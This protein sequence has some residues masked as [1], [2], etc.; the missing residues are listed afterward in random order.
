MTQLLIFK[1]VFD[2]YFKLLY[3]IHHTKNLHFF[4]PHNISLYSLFYNYTIN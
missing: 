2:E 1:T 4:T 3:K